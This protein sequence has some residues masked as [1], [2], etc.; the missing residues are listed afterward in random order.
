MRGETHI[1][2]TVKIDWFFAHLMMNPWHLCGDVLP[3]KAVGRMTSGD[4]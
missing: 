1:G 2:P 3:T 4:V